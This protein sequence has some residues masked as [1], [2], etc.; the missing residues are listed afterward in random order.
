MKLYKILIL[1]LSAGLLVFHSCERDSNKPDLPEDVLI[2]N[3]WIWDVMNEVYLWENQLPDLDPDYQPDPMQY[4]YDLLYE[5]DHYSWIV[6]NYDEL[7]ALFDGVEFVTGMSA[8][9]WLYTDTRVLYTVEFVT[10]GSPAEDAGIKRGDLIVAID[11]QSITIDNYYELYSQATATYEFGE[12][13]GDTVLAS[14][15]KI[16]LTAIDLN[17]NPVVHSEIIDFQGKKIGY[18]VYTQFTAGADDEWYDELNNVFQEFKSEGVS[19]VV[20]DLRYNRGG[21]LELAAY[22]A[23]TL[24]P[25]TA[26]ENEDVFSYLVWNDFYNDFWKEYDADNDGK[27]DG[28]ESEILVMRLPHSDLNLDLSKIYFLTT[29]STASASESLIVGLYPYTDVVQIGTTTYGK[30]YGSWTIPDYAEPK[31][32]NWAMQPIVLK[33]SNAE[34]FTNFVDGIDPDYEIYENL[35]ELEPFGSM[36][37]PLLA[38]A[39]EEITGVQPVRKGTALPEREFIPMPLPEKRVPEFISDLPV[40]AEGKLRSTD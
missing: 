17:Q 16:T 8:L 40:R 19:D 28:D 7:E 4:F 14:G 23:S 1:F 32:H 9:P 37:D 5:E 2:L 38:K 31:R 34:G 26:M 21:M 12:W 10:P 15:R 25:R 35:L 18:L 6:D 22:I 39:L 33:Y 30:C 24:G 20:F 29:G 3:H 27:P 11:G 13:N 36:E